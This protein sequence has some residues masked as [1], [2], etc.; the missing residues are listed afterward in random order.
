MIPA[1]FAPILFGLILSGLMSLLVSGVA[2]QRALG[3]PPGFVM[4]W[5][6]AWLPSWAVAFPTVLV[7]AP[8]TRRIVAALTKA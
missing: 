3:L 2:T 7:V 5:I 1:R 8:F 6:G 4:A